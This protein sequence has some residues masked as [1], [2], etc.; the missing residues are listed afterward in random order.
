MTRGGSAAGARRPLFVHDGSSYTRDAR[1]AH[2][3]GIDGTIRPV[4]RAPLHSPDF[5]PAG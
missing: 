2:R 5:P 3:A 4:R 1:G